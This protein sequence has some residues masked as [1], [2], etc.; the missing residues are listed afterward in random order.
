MARQSF[1]HDWRFRLASPQKLDELRDALTPAFDDSSWRRLSLPHDWSIELPRSPDHPSGSNG[2]FFMDGLGWYRKTFEAPAAWQ[3]KRIRLEFEGA[4]HNAELWLNGRVLAEHPYGYTGFFVDLSELLKFGQKN[5]LA[6]RL[7]ATG[8]PHTRW[9]AGPGIYRHVWLHLQPPVHLAPWGISITTPAVSD[10]QAQVGVTTEIQNA[11]PLEAAV[12]LS[13]TILDPDGKE[14]ARA[15]QAVVAA[16]SETTTAA[17]TIEVS[18]PKRWSVDCPAL[19]R[20]ETRLSVKGSETDA[21]TISFGIRTIRF[22]PAKGFM[23]NEQPLLLKGGCVHHDCGPLGSQ[24]INRAEERKVELLKAC[25]YN[26][27]RCAHNPPSPAFLDACDRLGMLVMNEA[28]D[29]WQL[30]KIPFDYHRH[31]NNW[32]QR[33]L[34]SMLRRDRNHPSI[35]LWSIGNELIER[36]FPEGARLAKMLA[37]HVRSTEPTRPVTAGIHCLWETKEPWSTLDDLFATLDVCGYNYEVK[38]SIADHERHPQRVILSTESFAN[39][40]FEYWK[41]VEEYPHI[42]GDFTWSALDYLGEAGIGRTYEKGT[43]EPHMAGWPWHQANCGDMDICGWKR[44]QSFYRDVL[45]GLAQKPFIAVHPPQPEGMKLVVH[46][47][48]WHDVQPSWN[49]PTALGG[50]LQVDVYFDSDE[51]ELLLNGRSLGRQPATAAQRYIATFHVPY[52]P[53]TLKAVA[54]SG[55][56]AVAEQTLH[57]TGPAVRLVLAADRDTLE[58]TPDDL[59]YVTVKALDAEGHLVPT[60]AHMVYFTLRGPA[61]LAAVASANPSHTEPYRGN[62]HSLWRGRA[63]AVVRP[64]GTPGDVILQAHADGV[65]GATLP[66]TCQMPC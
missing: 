39:Q 16:P 52:E 61:E 47:W 42:A 31:F 33:D 9:Y 6:V 20:L 49:W 15:E 3:G 45:W 18:A 27:V 53:G 26:A 40:S 8:S 38:T 48:G 17:Q 32:W 44:P 57:T 46:P 36:G 12:T 54:W 2:G 23:L 60:A 30:E 24:A 28:F 41:A 59:A 21:Q 64:H 4:Y 1:D 62:T 14:V 10:Q 50:A 43:V 55:G 66:I 29:V 7:D 35:I 11:A 34:D 19:Y 63:L 25:G 37:D 58:A 65:T 56:K 22:T 51:I 5:V 13:W